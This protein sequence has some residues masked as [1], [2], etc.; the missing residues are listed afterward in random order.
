MN[1]PVSPEIKTYDLKDYGH[2]LKKILPGAELSPKMFG[3]V[4]ASWSIQLTEQFDRM[5]SEAEAERI[6]TLLGEEMR[7]VA[8]RQLG[9]EPIIQGWTANRHA[10]EHRRKI[11]YDMAN[12]KVAEKLAADMMSKFVNNSTEETQ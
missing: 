12:E 9:L 11:I 2:I 6:I 5:P 7:L 8:M 1:K 10:D 3:G 4:R